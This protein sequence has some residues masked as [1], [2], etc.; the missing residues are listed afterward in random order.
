MFNLPSDSQ[1]NRRTFRLELVRSLPAGVIETVGTTFAVFLAVSVF[2]ASQTQKAVLVASASVGL[3]LSLFVVQFVRR[4]GCSVNA[5]ICG[6]SFFAAAG[7]LLAACQPE[8]L[9]WYLVGM[10]G[11]QLGLTLS[12]PLFSQIYR[13]HYPDLNR[14]QLFAFTAI[15]RK[16]AA[17][18]TGLAFGFWLRER[19]DD[20]PWLLSCYALCCVLM[21]VCVMAMAP[22]KLRKTVGVRLFDAF[23]HVRSDAPFRKLLI[24]WMVLGF[25]N[26]LCFGI[27]VEFVANPDYGYGLSADQVSLITTTTPEAC[28]LVTVFLWGVVFDRVNF[29]SVRIII[30]LFFIAAVLVFFLG[31]AVWALYLGLALHGIGKAGGNVAWSLWV[32]K[33]AHED[34]VAEYMSVHTFLTG[35]RGTAAPFIGFTV[36]AAFSP[37]VVG[38]IGAT[39]MT[40]STFMI[41]PQFKESL[42]KDD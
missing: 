19:P 13:R 40:L 22:I 37:Q 4:L 21:A 2:G 12:M 32:T 16:L 24:A 38:I 11:A 36:A 1:W 5:A 6:L 10:C 17:V 27:F 25:G 42:R 26:L 15:F 28:F 29:F 14:G 39:L 31:G 18:L 33:F 35:C 3:L 7:F 23:G 9:L 34:H 41:L 8:S 20:Y 30:N